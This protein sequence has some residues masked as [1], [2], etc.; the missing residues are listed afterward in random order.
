VISC[1]RHGGH[2]CRRLNQPGGTMPPG[3][4]RRRRVAATKAWSVTSNDQL[5]DAKDAMNARTKIFLKSMNTK[6][7][8][9]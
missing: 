2:G 1:R 9:L 7:R 3:W 5:G 6:D 4:F 8:V